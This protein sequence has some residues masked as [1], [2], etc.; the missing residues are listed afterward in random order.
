MLRIFFKKIGLSLLFFLAVLLFEPVLASAYTITVAIGDETGALIP[1]VTFKLDG[2]AKTATLNAQKEYVIKNV[3]TGDHTV[4]PSKKGWTFEQ[5]YKSLT[6]PTNGQT[7]SPNG[8]LEFTGVGSYNI[9]GQVY[10]VLPDGSKQGIR[11]ITV[12]LKDTTIST[13]TDIDGNYLIRGLMPGTYSVAATSKAFLLTPATKSI[14][15][16]TSGFTYSPDGQANF[17]ATGKY[18]IKG[19]LTTATGAAIAGATVV[20]SGSDSTGARDGVEIIATTDSTGNYSCSGLPSGIFTVIP[21]AATNNF[22]PASKSITL[23]TSGLAYSPNGKANFTGASAG[24]AKTMLPLS[25]YFVKDS[26]GWALNSAAEGVMFFE[27]NS[28]VQVYLAFSDYSISYKGTYGYSGG[29]LHLKFNDADLVLDK[30]FTLD[31]TQLTVTMPF[32]LGDSTVAGSSTW[33][34]K[35]PSVVQG[36]SSLFKAVSINENLYFDQAIARVLAYAYAMIEADSSAPAL[37]DEVETLTTAPKM[38]AIRRIPYGLVLQ[39]DKGPDQS[40]ILFGWSNKAGQPLTLSPLAGDPRLNLAVVPANADSDPVNKTALLISPFFTKKTLVWYDVEWRDRRAVSKTVT[41]FHFPTAADDNIAGMTT[42]LEDRGYAVTQLN[43]AN[44]T[45]EK[46]IDELLKS[47][48]FINFST[49]GMSDGKLATGVAIGNSKTDREA[50]IQAKFD[51]YV[52]SLRLNPTYAK[53]IDYKQATSGKLRTLDISWVPGDLKT[54][55]TAFI[56]VTPFFWEALRVAGGA[57]FSDSLVYINACSTDEGAYLSKLP[58]LTL[59]DAIKSRAYFAYTVPAEPGFA[60][61]VFQYLVK[62]LWHR[63]RSA[64]EAYYNILRVANTRQMIYVEDKVLDGNIPKQEAMT[65][66]DGNPLNLKI[67]DMFRGYGN[68]AETKSKTASYQSGGWLTQ[69]NDYFDLGSVWWL[70]FG[71]RWG[72]DAQDSAD[73]IKDV[74]YKNYW[75]KGDAGG[76]SSPGCNNWAGGGVPTTQEIGYSMYLLTGGSPIFPTVT[77]RMPRWTMNDSL[78]P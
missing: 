35:R 48:G 20:C 66:D 12:S 45:V 27:P 26:D 21:A 7:Y 1:G 58:P 17:S 41:D 50:R 6:L 56:T 73:A 78:A 67:Q 65:D 72:Q 47:P 54:T 5:S 22:T 19:R 2:A 46:L 75:S 63:T 71:G 9:S 51:S 32:K 53:I 59:R 44:V 52:A 14:T 61:A 30:T 25:Y 68:G 70:L 18:K 33:Q 11:N 8:R 76:L 15:L 23:P 55:D 37:A 60:G 28:I 69:G 49:H 34:M 39:F 4:A 16:P 29:K 57:D 3:A 43:D 62:H 64:E 13:N 24:N 77:P 74:C 40:L 31:T 38:T 36:L 10:K 42:T